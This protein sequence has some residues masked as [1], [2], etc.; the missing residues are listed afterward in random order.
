MYCCLVLLHKYKCHAHHAHHAYIMHIK[1]QSDFC[2]DPPLFIADLNQLFIKGAIQS[3]IKR[4]ELEFIYIY[5]GTSEVIY[6]QF[7]HV[8]YSAD[9][10]SSWMSS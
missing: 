4:K 10:G 7:L 5:K 6:K 2:L 8:Q 9:W 3:H 1:H